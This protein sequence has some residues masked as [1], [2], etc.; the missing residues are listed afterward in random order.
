MQ[1]DV[2]ANIEDVQDEVGETVETEAER[3]DEADAEA[4]TR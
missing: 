4:T 2:S 3:G 1:A